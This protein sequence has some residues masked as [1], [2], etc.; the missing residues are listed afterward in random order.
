[1]SA[2]DPNL[3]ADLASKA[4]SVQQLDDLLQHRTRLGACALLATA[5]ALTFSKLRDLLGET[6][7]NLGA[8]LRKLEDAG[9]VTVEKRFVDRK[10]QSTYTLTPKGRSHLTSHLAA[11]QS[12]LGT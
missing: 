12:L 6:D 3:S 10:P 9:Y 11:L 1:M 7:G 2:T 4:A 5:D 8:N